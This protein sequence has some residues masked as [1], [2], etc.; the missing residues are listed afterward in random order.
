LAPPCSAWC[1]PAGGS[2]RLG[3]SGVIAGLVVALAASQLLGSRLF[4]VSLTDAR[5]I[6]SGVA[7]VIGGMFLATLV[8]AWRGARTNPLAAIRHH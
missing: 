4:G 8:P 2:L 7:V 1:A 5:S 3:A 6:A